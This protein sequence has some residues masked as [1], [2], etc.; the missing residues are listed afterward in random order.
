MS[1]SVILGWVVVR[2]THKQSAKGATSYKE[3]K[4]SDMFTVEPSANQFRELALKEY[5]GANIIVRQV[6]G[7]EG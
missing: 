2:V 1:K 3:E 6:V 4:L 5:P 7:Q